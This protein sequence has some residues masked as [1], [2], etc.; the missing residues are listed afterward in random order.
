M[1]GH[2]GNNF[3]KQAT[4]RIGRK[5]KKKRTTEKNVNGNHKSD[6]RFKPMF[7]HE[8]AKIPRQALC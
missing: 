4:E 7:F 3:K 1:S 5:S 8:D 6:L 2:A